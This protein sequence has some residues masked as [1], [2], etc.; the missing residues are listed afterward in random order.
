M[1]LRQQIEEEMQREAKIDKI[2]ESIKRRFLKQ[3]VNRKYRIVSTRKEADAILIFNRNDISN[4][5][6]VLNADWA[7]ETAQII[8][9]NSSTVFYLK[10]RNPRDSKT[11]T[12]GDIKNIAARKKFYS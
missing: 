10:N 2:I 7:E 1:S 3:Q 4:Y 8:S 6:F 11:S 5:S 9:L 12:L